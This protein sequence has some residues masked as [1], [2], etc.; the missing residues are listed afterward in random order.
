MSGAHSS[1]NRWTLG[2][3]GVGMAT[4][5]STINDI[6]RRSLATAHV[7]AVLEPTYPPNLGLARSDGKRPD[8]MT[9]IPWRLGRFE[10]EEMRSYIFLVVILKEVLVSDKKNIFNKKGRRGYQGRRKMGG[11]SR[12]L[13]R[14]SE[15][16]KQNASYVLMVFQPRNGA[17]SFGA[18][19]FDGRKEMV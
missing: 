13:R 14:G 4:P 16:K 11:H 18:S 19:Q 15:R 10:V 9:L 3:Q 1:E 6:I 12:P 2:F 17:N 7:P 5:H 8:G